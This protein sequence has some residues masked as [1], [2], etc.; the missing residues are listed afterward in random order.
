MF[1]D[2]TSRIL[3]FAR[4]CCDDVAA[5]A[6]QRSRRLKR[7]MSYSRKISWFKVGSSNN[8]PHI[9]AHYY[10]EAVKSIKSRPRILRSD[11]GTENSI[12]SII[13]PVL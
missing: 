9:I 8:D 4:R 3:V 5:G 13:Q 10:I 1:F 6:A 2:K 7:R 11:L 12:V